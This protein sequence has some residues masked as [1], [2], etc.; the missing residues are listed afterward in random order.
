MLKTRKSCS[1]SDSPLS[2]VLE[3][4]L[5][6]IQQSVHWLVLW[7]WS[8]PSAPRC[9]QRPPFSSP[10][11]TSVHKTPPKV[12]SLLSLTF[13][14]AYFVS[15][16]ILHLPPGSLPG[17]H[18]SYSLS[19]SLTQPSAGSWLCQANFRKPREKNH[20]LPGSRL[21]NRNPTPTTDKPP[22]FVQVTTPI[23]ASLCS[24]GK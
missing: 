7:P 6:S 1:I 19:S 13:G 5:C 15:I 18:P 9:I 23:C 16:P 24:S 11:R 17:F 2:G 22:D 8:A 10:L 20:L 4:F 14:S 12:H 3:R 21:Q